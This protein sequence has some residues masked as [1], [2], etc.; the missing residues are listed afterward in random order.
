MTD[1]PPKPLFRIPKTPTNQFTN[2][3]SVGRL[4]AIQ[5]SINV[6]KKA[7]KSKS[8]LALPHESIFMETSFLLYN[9]PTNTNIDVYIYYPYHSFYFAI[10]ETIRSKLKFFRFCSLNWSDCWMVGWIALNVNR[11][12]K[13]H[14][15]RM[16]L[17]WSAVEQGGHGQWTC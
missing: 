10:Y 16:I 15:I 13:G 12:K 14:R 3:Q 5:K 17:R 1:S 8:K 7:I 11:Q 2:Q 4:R 6:L 9:N